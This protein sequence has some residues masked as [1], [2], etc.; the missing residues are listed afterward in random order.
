M[1]LCS[2]SAADGVA[3][4]LRGAPTLPFHLRDYVTVVSG[5]RNKGAGV[6]I[7]CGLVARTV[8]GKINVPYDVIRAEFDG[9][10]ETDRD[11]ESTKPGGGNA[12]TPTTFPSVAPTPSSSTAGGSAT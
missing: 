5:R 6:L 7:E 3:C 10:R 8:D 2:L 9:G 4:A 12:F 11:V 1:S